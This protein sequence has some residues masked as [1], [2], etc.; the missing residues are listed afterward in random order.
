L[1][2]N[3]KRVEKNVWQDRRKGGLLQVTKKPNTIVLY[4]RNK[5][6][7]T[8]AIG[9]CKHDGVKVFSWARPDSASRGLGLGLASSHAM[10]TVPGDL[11][12]PVIE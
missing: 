7:V 12:G 10:M 4:Q 8:R 1:A 11:K 9:K 5:L 2:Q 3:E 6:V